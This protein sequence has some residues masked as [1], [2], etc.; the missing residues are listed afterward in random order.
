MAPAV[1]AHQWCDD[2]VQFQCRNN[3]PPRPGFGN[4]VSIEYQFFTGAVAAKFHLTRPGDDRQEGMFT[5]PP[6]GMKQ[7]LQLDFPVAGT[8]QRNTL[9]LPETG[10]SGEPGAELSCGALLLGVSESL[11]ALPELLPQAGLGAG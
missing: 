6:G 5:R 1:E 4:A 8:V 10:E 9:T 11:S 3:V 2:K 7:L